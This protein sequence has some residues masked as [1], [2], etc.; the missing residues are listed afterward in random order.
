M[1]RPVLSEYFQK[2]RDGISLAIVIA[3]V[4][5]VF[6]PVYAA[7]ALGLG[8]SFVPL[9]LWFGLSLN[10]LLNLM[11]EAAHSLVFRTRRASD[12]LGRWVLAPLVLADFDSYRDRHWQH[13]KRLGEPDDTKDTYLVDVR[14]WASAALLGRCLIMVEAARKFAHQLHTKTPASGLRRGG[15]HALARIVVVHAAFASSLLAIAWA[16]QRD[17]S[18]ALSSAAAAYGLVY[19]YGLG[20]LT[21]LAATVRAVAEHQVGDDGSINE[22]RAALRNF[23]AGPISRFFLG[24][25]GFAEHATH[26]YEPAIPYYRLP[27]ATGIL[28]TARPE[29]TPRSTYFRTLRRL[30]ARTGL[31]KRPTLGNEGT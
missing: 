29:L 2:R 15:G 12:I 4:T 22:G 6:A 25:Y 11:H 21:L 5:V 20:S 7:A 16:A 18:R 30:S 10:G 26:H 17:F 31:V 3:N 19:L 1:S 8:W 28:I 9:W 24:G 27:A 13:H 23:K 14:G